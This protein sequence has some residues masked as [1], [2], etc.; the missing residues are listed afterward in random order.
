MRTA[1]ALL[2]VVIGVS[3]VVV[4]TALGDGVKGFI[5]GQVDS[6]GS[7]LIQ[8]EVKVPST[9]K[10]SAENVKGPTKLELVKSGVADPV[11]VACR[12]NFSTQL[13]GIFCVH[14]S[15]NIL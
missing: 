5:L 8:V 14:C 2:G 9:G 7:D 13:V 6:F 15:V 12:Y 11:L 4:V 1:L 3:A 10:M